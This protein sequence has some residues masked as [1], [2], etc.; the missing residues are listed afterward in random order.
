MAPDADKLRQRNNVSS[1]SKV[2]VEEQDTTNS[3]Q[4]Q[5][6]KTLKSLK[7]NEVLIDGV[8]YDIHSFDHPGGDSINMFGG[9]DATTQYNMIHPYHTSHHLKKMTRVGVVPNYQSE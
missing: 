8:V 3:E 4:E 5:V 2:V 7:G 6:I 9:N 1:S